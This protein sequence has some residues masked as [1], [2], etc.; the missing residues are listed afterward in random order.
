LIKNIELPEDYSPEIPPNDEDENA[1]AK[2]NSL[3]YILGVIYQNQQ[4]NNPVWVYESYKNF[5][6]AKDFQNKDIHQMIGD[7]YKK[8]IEEFENQ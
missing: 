7:I 1:K 8:S 4:G 6:Q 2:P 3:T 5:F